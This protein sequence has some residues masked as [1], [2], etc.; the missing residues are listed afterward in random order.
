MLI[1]V[2][3]NMNV[4]VSAD[5]KRY[6]QESVDLPG[7]LIQNIYPQKSLIPY[8]FHKDFSEFK[9]SISDQLTQLAPQFLLRCFEMCNY[10]SI[11][12]LKSIDIPRFPRYGTGWNQG[13]IL[14]N[15]LI[16]S[17]KNRFSS[18]YDHK[19][20]ISYG[21]YLAYLNLFRA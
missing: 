1:T 13:M 19:A 4:Y 10:M 9:V 11:I 2:G 6:V 5:I 3:D 21:D 16:A 8:D 14:G 7:K 17:S 20:G 18:R 12:W 15:C